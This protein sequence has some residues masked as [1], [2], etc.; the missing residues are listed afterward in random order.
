MTWLVNITLRAQRDLA[1]F[2]AA[3]EAD[4]PGAARRWYQGLRKAILSLEAMPHRCPVVRKR[5]QIREL[6]YGRKPNVY[7]VLY[8]IREKDQEVDVLHI[9][10]GA[11]RRFSASELG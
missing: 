7:L 1:G 4:Q 11:R 10:H 2:Y 3:F 9:R 5:A 6:L 8:R